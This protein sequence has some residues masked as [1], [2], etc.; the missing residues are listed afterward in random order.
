MAGFTH[1]KSLDSTPGK[2]SPK[3]LA[4][5]SAL[6]ITG[7]SK[8]T[9]TDCSLVEFPQQYHEKKPSKDDF[10]LPRHRHEMFLKA[11]QCR[12]VTSVR[13][14][15]TRCNVAAT[16][17]KCRIHIDVSLE[18]P[19]EI[20]PIIPCGEDN[21]DFPLHHFQYQPGQ[22]KPLMPGD[23]IDRRVFTCSAPSCSAR[24][25]V[26][27]SLPHLSSFD[28]R[29]LSDRATINE[30]LRKVKELY[31]DLIS[32]SRTAFDVMHTLNL[33]LSNALIGKTSPIPRNHKRFVQDLGK[34]SDGIFRKAHFQLSDDEENWIPPDFGNKS[35]KR[36]VEDILMEVRLLMMNVKPTDKDTAYRLVFA[37]RELNRLLSCEKYSTKN[38]GRS[39]NPLDFHPRY[40]NLGALGDFSDKLIDWCYR[41]QKEVDPSNAPY[42]LECLA[43]LANGR[44]SETLQVAVASYR[45]EG[46]FSTGD[47]RE[48]FRALGL[49]PNKQHEP[50]VIKGKFEAYIAD[51]PKQEAQM[52][53][54]LV[55]I[56]TALRSQEII[57]AAQK[58]IMDVN[59]AY[60]YF[61]AE[62]STDPSYLI[63]LYQLKVKDQPNEE[64]MAKDALRLIAEARKSSI[65]LDFI[66][67]G[68][69]YDQPLDVSVAYSRLEI[70]PDTSDDMVIGVFSVR[71][72]D[73]ANNIPDLREALRT[74]GE[75][76]NSDMIRTYLN[77]GEIPSS[78]TGRNDWPVGLENIGN[79]CY[80]N[81][82]LQ[83]YF[84]ITPLREMILQFDVYQ[85]DIVEEI[86]QTKRVGG[87]RLTSKEVERAKKFVGHLR[88]LFQNMI[89]SKDASVTPE[90]DLAYLALVSSKDEAK[91]EGKRMSIDGLPPLI[92]VDGPE[93]KMDVD[94]NENSQTADDNASEI[95]LVEKV[96]P[97][98]VDEDFV[99]I[100]LENKKDISTLEDKEN[101]PPKLE[102]TSGLVRPILQDI[103]VNGVQQAEGYP[104][105]MSLMFG[106]QQDVAECI[107]NVMFQIEAAVKPLGHDENGEQIDLVK[108]LFYG[109]TKQSLQVV[110]SL[111]RRSKI[112][113][114]SHLLI[115]VADGSRDIYSALDSVFDVSA[116][117]L[118]GKDTIRYL[119][120]SE[121]PRVLQLQ[122]QRVQFDRKNGRAY[123]S[124]AH[125]RFSETIYMD[126]Y[127]DSDDPELQ[128]KRE[129]AWRW[130]TEIAS[131]EKRKAGL[132]NTSVNLEAPEALGAVR[133]WLQDISEGDDKDIVD[134][135]TLPDVLSGL[136]EG[137]D[138][139]SK[140]L[141]VINERLGILQAR[142][143]AQFEGLR[144][145]G[146]R[147]HSVFIHR[148]S[149]SFGHYWIYIYDFKQKIWRKYNDGYVTQVDNEREV[150]EQ[151]DVNPATPY[152]LV[153]VREDQTELV[154]AVERKMEI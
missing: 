7:L 26:F 150:F 115:D 76:R 139:A 42:Y 10:P 134:Q 91:D 16:C 99:M 151:D 142:A 6:D 44:N 140:E 35:F 62:E 112:E 88:T 20:L 82:L 94:V 81:S 92:T 120:I 38:E 47:V 11:D 23:R 84:T 154:E 122:I 123:K 51:A 71:L 148:G 29:L 56:G 15:N 32:A 8:G 12:L 118:E 79:T 3:I 5:L 50:S 149:A 53:Q 24:L 43:D 114:F 73:G 113:L 37:D 45:S 4:D 48:A 135:N 19:K 41:R 67:S 141:K 31:P 145:F 96:E 101:L 58:V 98:P 65:L 36:D 87:R 90:Y 2:T 116:V 107:E 133:R 54:A 34:D 14:L 27:S 17:R 124:T 95:T 146:Y 97:K 104:K 52:R 144:K 108:Q 21:S 106:R 109:K 63:T 132:M 131:L 138:S 75:T 46:E 77:T 80:L 86:L 9:T 129:E 66:Q 78:H 85:E 137:I 68:N 102:P 61:G 130:K 18:F 126:R 55:M 117:N 64:T 111:E 143:A 33:Y 127:I 152:F 49:D 28:E 119:S 39:S 60:Q 59:Q 22:S 70:P 110:G 105:D 136:D 103:G 74:I 153:F 1:D 147:I 30:R 40:A 93:S 100:D 25:T 13:D 57:Q 83:F 121:L 89:S 72:A 128:S 125:L 69:I